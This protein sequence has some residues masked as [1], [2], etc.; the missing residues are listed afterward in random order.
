MTAKRP[1]TLRIGGLDYTVK[2]WNK[3]AAEN[4]GC[5][6]LCD[7]TTLTI[8]VCEG[9]PPQ[10]EAEVLLH[11]VLHAAYDVGG[12]NAIAEHLSEERLV[13]VLTYQLIAVWR[14]NPQLVAYLEGTLRGSR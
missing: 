4:A 5:W 1:A 12:L 11:E 14:D 3:Q 7:R 10:R 9:L 8:L 6:G 2:E 13:G